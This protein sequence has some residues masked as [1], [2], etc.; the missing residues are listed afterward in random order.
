M[1]SHLCSGQEALGNFD[2]NFIMHPHSLHCE[3]DFMN[4]SHPR[5]MSKRVSAISVST[6]PMFLL[7]RS[8]GLAGLVLSVIALLKLFPRSYQVLIPETLVMGL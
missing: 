4:L 6:R 3:V 2:F 1:A 8:H 5:H 7:K